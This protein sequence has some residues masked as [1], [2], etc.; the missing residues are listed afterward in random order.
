MKHIRGCWSRCGHLFEWAAV[1]HPLVL[2]R[3]AAEGDDGCDLDLADKVSIFV[4]GDIIVVIVDRGQV[5]KPNLS[6]KR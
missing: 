4:N 3:R 5:V 6:R 2:R 1:G